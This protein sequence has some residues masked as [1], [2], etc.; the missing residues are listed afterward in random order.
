MSTSTINPQSLR[1]GMPNAVAFPVTFVVFTLGTIIPLL[2]GVAIPFFE[3][4]KMTPPIFTQFLG[5]I[6]PLAWT[7]SAVGISMGLVIVAKCVTIER[8]WILSWAVIGLAA[9]L[10]LIGMLAFLSPLYSVVVAIRM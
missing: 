1:T 2:Y 3:A 10:T 8:F 4:V 6:P 7:G 9:V 5:Q